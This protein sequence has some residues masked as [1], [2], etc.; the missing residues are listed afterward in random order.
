[1]GRRGPQPIERKAG[2]GRALS[3]QRLASAAR[4]FAIQPAG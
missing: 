4:T 3:D 2:D 1:M